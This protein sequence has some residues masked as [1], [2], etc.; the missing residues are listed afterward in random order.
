MTP[1]S[2][3]LED[4][5]NACTGVG[6]G[7]EIY[8]LCDYILQ[9]VFLRM[10][11]AQEQKLKCICWEM[12][13]NDFEYRYEYIKMA[14]SDYGEFSTYSQKNNVY[15]Q[16]LDEIRKCNPHFKVEDIYWIDNGST[17]LQKLLLEKEYLLRIKDKLDS[18]ANRASLS[19]EAKERIKENIKKECEKNRVAILA[20]GFRRLFVI[21]LN[22]AMAHALKDTILAIGEQRNF[23]YCMDEITK[24]SVD[25]FATNGNLLGGDLKQLYEND[26]IKHRHRCAHN[27]TS[28]QQNLP[29]LDSLAD[30]EHPYH[31]YYFRFMILILIDEIFMRLY[32]EYTESLRRTGSYVH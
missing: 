17:A 7:I 2:S 16:L 1:L 23:S 20:K 25:T 31:N 5:A 26:V 14:K 15:T 19:G 3:I 24:L 10:T 18:N 21:G 27:L 4:G 8:P 30:K 11:G 6:T 9:S 28:Y 12:A 29:T 22:H 32:E 13:T